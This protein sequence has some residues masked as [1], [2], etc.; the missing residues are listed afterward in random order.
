MAVLAMQRASDDN[1]HLNMRIAF[2]NLVPAGDMHLT[3]NHAM[4]PARLRGTHRS[5]L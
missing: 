2:V 1:H 5:L 4:R 3:L